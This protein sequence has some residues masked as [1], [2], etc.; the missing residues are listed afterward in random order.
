MCFEYQIF[1]N[2]KSLNE[3][4][5]FL[6]EN[7]SKMIYSDHFTKYSVDLIRSYSGENSERI[8]GKDFNISEINSGSWILYNKKHIEELRLQ[9]FEFPDF[10]I[11]KSSDFKKVASFQDFIFYEKLP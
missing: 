3:L 9:H 10:S 1:F 6:R 7:S 5:Y 2:N 4:K 11:L 8:I